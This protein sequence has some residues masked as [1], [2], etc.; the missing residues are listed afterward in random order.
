[1]LHDAGISPTGVLTAGHPVPVEAGGRSTDT[2]VSMTEAVR[3][4]K[5]EQLPARDEIDE[6]APGV[7]RLQL[8]IDM[9]GLGHVNCYALEDANGFALIDPGLP[10]PTAWAHLTKRLAAAAIPLARVH[11]VIVTHSHPDHYGG[12]AQL[13]ALSGARIV[14]HR[15]FRVRWLQD[16]GDDRDIEDRV[17][18]G[19]FDDG[20]VARAVSGRAASTG[21]VAQDT[22]RRRPAPWGGAVLGPPPD[23]LREMEAMPYR[24]LHMRPTVRLDDADVISLARRDWVALHTPGHTADHLC[25]FDPEYGVMFSGDHVLPT[26]TPHIGGDETLGDPLL[27]FFE[28]LDKVAAYGRQTTVVLPAHGHAFADI[29]GRAD[30]IKHHHAGRLEVLRRTSHELGRPA[31]VVEMSTHLFSPRAQGTM[32]DSETYAH[33]EHLRLMG[34]A[35]VRHVGGILHYEVR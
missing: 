35:D 26:I 16:D 2:V 27:R 17:T 3:S 7:L 34:Q 18:D 5:Q 31:S 13:R 23:R 24:P 28:S 30:S 8:T 32:A 29:A 33:L 12:A 11:T 10:G 9:P 25:L 1:L 15:Q 20:A 21:G 4:P 19:A 6:V 14:G 22:D